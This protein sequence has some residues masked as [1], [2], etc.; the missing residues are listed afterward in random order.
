MCT[1][2]L[3]SNGGNVLLCKMG[4]LM[5][6]LLSVLTFNERRD[7]VW[8]VVSFFPACEIAHFCVLLHSSRLLKLRKK[9]K[10]VCGICVSKAYACENAQVH[11]PYFLKYKP[12]HIDSAGNFLCSSD[13]YLR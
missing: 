5:A 7:S 4:H 6:E 10:I 13:I 11:I 2:F 8:I 12:W 3:D 9:G 1:D